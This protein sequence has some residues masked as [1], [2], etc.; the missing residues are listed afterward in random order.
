MIS[1]SGEE[2][3][4]NSSQ[5]YEAL[6]RGYG[7]FTTIKV[8]D[9]NAIWLEEH[10][11]RLRSHLQQLHL[12]DLFSYQQIEGWVLKYLSLSDNQT[13]N[14]PK[15]FGLKIS[16][17]PDNPLKPSRLDCLLT[18][19]DLP[20]EGI[21]QQ[22][23]ISPKILHT[24]RVNAGIK[25]LSY[26]ENFTALRWALSQGADDVVF[27]NEHE[28]VVESAIANLFIRINDTWITPKLDS[29]CLAGITRKHLIQELS[30]E[31]QNF[32]IETLKQADEIILTNALRINQATLI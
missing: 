14:H 15:N 29:G 19:R 30:V 5:A 22:L 26:A 20:E 12:S 31:E 17:Y 9:G 18:Q 4:L 24:Q 8:L 2:L 27:L 1:L 23:V 13:K 32:G 16:I 21:K 6:S 28:Q 10:L 7:V 11:E 25:S 3:P